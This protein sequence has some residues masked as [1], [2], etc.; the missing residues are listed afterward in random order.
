ML[1]SRVALQQVVANLLVNAAESIMESCTE[2]GR[3]LVSARAELVDGVPMAHFCF[4]DNGMGI[5]EED[6]K[7]V[8]ERN[9]STKKRNSGLGLHWSANTVSSL[10]GLLY[11]GNNENPRGACL[12]ILL[13]QAVAQEQQNA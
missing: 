9:F 8:F 13:P 5:R 1:A 4:A 3:L 2:G 7:H 6:L 10:G 11:A 12:H